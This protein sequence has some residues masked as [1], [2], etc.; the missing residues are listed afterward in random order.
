MSKFVSYPLL[1]GLGWA[2]AVLGSA[3]GVAPSP[4]QSETETS[5]S[6]TNPAPVPSPSPTVP[7]DVLERAASKASS[8]ANLAE[9]AVTKDDWNLVFLQW[10]RAIAFLKQ[11]PKS[12][13]RWATAQKLLPQY[14]QGLQRAQA[15]SKR[16]TTVV[17]SG[18]S[19]AGAS[20]GGILVAGVAMPGQESGSTAGAG[21]IAVLNA[22]NQK[23]IAFFTQQN[24]FAKTLA[25]LGKDAASNSADYVF[26]T[27]SD[28]PKQAFS[29]AIA[30]KDG[31]PSYISAIFAVTDGKKQTSTVSAICATQQPSKVALANPKLVNKQIQCSAG[32]VAV[33]SGEPGK[34]QTAASPTPQ[35]TASSSA[36]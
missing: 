6:V 13:A 27:T 18:S 20:G 23:Q 2:I 30:Q 29:S 7:A 34:P 14:Q 16:G 22:L 15:Q 17:S 24:R 32:S 10:Q 35:P 3:C 33:N 26:G 31:L 1:A 36:K 4:E 11:I 9:T 28:Q 21:A 19:A 25:E 8:A 12:D 5:I